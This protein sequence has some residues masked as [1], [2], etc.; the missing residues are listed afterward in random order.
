MG[1]DIHAYGERRNADG[2]WTLIPDCTPFQ[3]RNYSL[4]AWLADVRN[5]SAAIGPPGHPEPTMDV[6]NPEPESARVQ[7]WRVGGVYGLGVSYDAWQVK[8]FAEI[9][10][11]FTSGQGYPGFSSWVSVQVGVRVDL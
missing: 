4:F 1:C 10:Q 9:N 5:Y 6:S 7:G 11:T 3:H 8:P 2:K